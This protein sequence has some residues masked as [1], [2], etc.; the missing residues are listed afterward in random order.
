MGIA[1]TRLFFL[2]THNH[3]PRFNSALNIIKQ[4]LSINNYNEPIFEQSL[5][6]SH[7]WSKSGHDLLLF[8][9]LACQNA[10]RRDPRRDHTYF[11]YNLLL[12]AANNH[13]HTQ[14]M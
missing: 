8:T 7:I 9:H 5:T 10:N 2:M 11:R 14:L 4:H 6:S 13:Q 3:H 1:P 12:L